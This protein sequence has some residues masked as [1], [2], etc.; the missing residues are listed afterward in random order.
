MNGSLYVI[1]FLRRRG[2]DISAIP[3]RPTSYSTKPRNVEWC[4]GAKEYLIVW[5]RIRKSS[6][7]MSIGLLC[8]TLNANQSRFF[9]INIWEERGCRESTGNKW[10]GLDNK[11]FQ[12]L[13]NSEPTF[14][15]CKIRKKLSLI[16]LFVFS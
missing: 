8:F 11:K 10:L 15:K 6:A 1:V 7:K 5:R 13:H 16:S 14:K 12:E 2:D 3:P 4:K 9:K